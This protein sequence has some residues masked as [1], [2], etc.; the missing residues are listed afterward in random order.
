MPAFHPRARIRDQRETGRMGFW[1]A[2]GPESFQLREC[3][4]REFRLVAIVNHPLNELRAEFGDASGTA[5]LRLI[6][7]RDAWST[8]VSPLRLDHV[9]ALVE[10]VRILDHS[11]NDV[12]D[13]RDWSRLVDEP[14]RSHARPRGPR[15]SALAGSMTAKC[16]CTRPRTCRHSRSSC[17]TNT[18]APTLPSARSRRWALSGLSM[19]GTTMPSSSGKEIVMTYRRNLDEIGLLLALPDR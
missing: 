13:I 9:R 14:F 10:P 5:A 17:A 16:G 1:E 19:T 15:P 12:D 7:S 2:I 18:A 8:R 6:G 4:Q 3:L 11:E